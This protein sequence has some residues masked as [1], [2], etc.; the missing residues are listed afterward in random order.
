MKTKKFIQRLTNYLAETSDQSEKELVEEW[1]NSYAIDL[2]IPPLKKP[3]KE[4][5]L[6]SK[7]KAEIDRSGKDRFLLKAN[8]GWL[9]KAAAVIIL[10]STGSLLWWKW[11]NAQKEYKAQ[12][13]V[14]STGK[15]G[16]KKITLPDHSTVWLNTLGKLR[17]QR[18][19]DDKN[20]VIYLDEGEAFFEVTK[21]PDKPFSVYTPTLHT[22]VLGTSFNIKSYPSLNFVRV[23]VATGKVQVMKGLQ[24]YGSLTPGQQLTYHLLDG[25][26]IREQLAA[27]PATWINGKI[28]LHQADFYE[29]AQAIQSLYQIRLKAAQPS[30]LQLKY[31]LT[32][33]SNQPINE[34]LMIIN[35]IHETKTR[36]EGH[37]ITLYK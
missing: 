26:T 10:F 37:D 28:Q 29:L 19:F 17:F 31:T 32:L 33:E 36:R 7:I 6:F 9:W 34:V 20:R 3:E 22:R 8:Y 30:I 12:Y 11:Q 21:N 15:T 18:S 14:I 16:I 35:A 25:K 1:F 24:N 5:Q 23:T 4:E 27:G 13:V 2:D